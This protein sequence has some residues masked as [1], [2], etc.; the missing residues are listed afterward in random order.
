[1]KKKKVNGWKIFGKCLGWGLLIAVVAGVIC[2]F[3]VPEFQTFINNSW[4]DL[5]NKIQG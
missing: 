2:Y 5:T 3:A 1:M 4:Q